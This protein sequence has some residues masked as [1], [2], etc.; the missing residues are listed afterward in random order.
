MAARTLRPFHQEEVKAK[1]QASQLINR[2]QNHIDGKIEMTPTQVD[3]AKF[4]LNKRL[5]NA[6]TEINLGG[7][8][9]NPLV[10]KII[11]EIVSSGDKT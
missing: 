3:A 8:S 7:Q 10:T 9:D 11:T 4:L 5:G 6:A 2:L 1:I